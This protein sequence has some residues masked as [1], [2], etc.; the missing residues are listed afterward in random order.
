MKAKSVMTVSWNRTEQNIVFWFA[1]DERAAWKTLLV[2]RENLGLV[3][4]GAPCFI[5]IVLV[6]LWHTTVSKRDSTS[7]V[8]LTS[9]SI[10]CPKCKFSI[11]DWCHGTTVP[12]YHQSTK[13]PPVFATVSKTDTTCNKPGLSPQL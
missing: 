11:D 10:L 4:L 8:M 13:L 1:S 7:T 3:K 2:S 12:N 5:Y 9:I 6:K